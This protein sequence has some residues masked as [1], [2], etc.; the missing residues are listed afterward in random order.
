VYGVNAY[1]LP[2]RGRVIGRKQSRDRYGINIQR[3]LRK[4]YCCVNKGINANCAVL[5]R[6]APIL[7]AS[8]ISIDEVDK[9]EMRIEKNFPELLEER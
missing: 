9:T 2:D 5:L 1:N 7:T 6:G 4:D 3:L 8:G